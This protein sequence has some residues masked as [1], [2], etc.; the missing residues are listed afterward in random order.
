M[1]ESKYGEPWVLDNRTT[2][3]INDDGTEGE[4]TTGWWKYADDDK[5][6]HEIDTGDYFTPRIATAKRVVACVNA[7][8]GAEHPERLRKLLTTLAC[9]KTVGE[10][11]LGVTRATTREL[12][13]VFTAYRA[14][15]EQ[16][17][18]S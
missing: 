16:D 13:A 2:Y 15:M 7:L 14:L 3:E 12:D 17:D 9:V 5:E 18:G 11:A 1:S 6:R 4:V 8:A 10:P